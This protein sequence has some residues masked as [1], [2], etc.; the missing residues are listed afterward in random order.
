MTLATPEE[1]ERVFRALQA[2]GAAGA[3]PSLLSHQTAMTLERVRAAL[4]ALL[5]SKQVTIVRHNLN[6]RAKKV[7]GA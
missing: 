3:S 2:C 7:W 6:W 4:D 1:R 5:E